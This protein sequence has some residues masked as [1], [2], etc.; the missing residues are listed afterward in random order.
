MRKK[1][2]TKPIGLIISEEVYN[3]VVEQTNKEEV[4]ISEWIREAIDMRL[5]KTQSGSHY[6]A[7]NKQ[8]KGE[9]K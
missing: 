1:H 6:A 2:F 4:T 8:G 5:K 3:Q 7:N 9:L